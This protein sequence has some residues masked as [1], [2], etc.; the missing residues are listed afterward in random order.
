MCAP[1]MLLRTGSLSSSHILN[2]LV[3]LLT[4][5]FVVGTPFLNVMNLSL[6]NCYCCP[7]PL[8]VER[9]LITSL[10]LILLLFLSSA[11]CQLADHSEP[12]VNALAVAVDREC[13]A[14][15]L[16]FICKCVL[17]CHKCILNVLCCVPKL[18]VHCQLS[19]FSQHSVKPIKFV[20][21]SC[22]L[23]HT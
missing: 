7:L 20:S 23:F 21:D 22:G 18:F 1:V 13:F 4:L 16:C 3:V 12:L 14:H 10:S 19:L 15:S 8:L 17:C 9:I 2:L 5:L 11:C 6:F